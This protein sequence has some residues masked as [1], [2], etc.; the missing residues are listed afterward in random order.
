MSERA[1]V[2]V[3]MIEEENPDLSATT[4]QG[5]ECVAGQEQAVLLHVSVLIGMGTRPC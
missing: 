5:R 1:F 3:T 4:A 2:C